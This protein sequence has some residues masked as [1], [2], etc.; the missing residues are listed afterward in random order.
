ML[1]PTPHP[2]SPPPAHHRSLLQDSQLLVHA[3]I[4]SL[5]ATQVSEY[6]RAA[7]QLG[8]LN[9]MLSTLG[10]A[11]IDSTKWMGYASNVSG[12]LLASSG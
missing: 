5:N 11:S 3:T 1:K 2:L 7:Q 10:A 8:T 4:Y 6:L 9:L 12:G